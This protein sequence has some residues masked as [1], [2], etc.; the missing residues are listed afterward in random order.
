MSFGGYLAARAAAFE[1][2]LRAAVFFD[3][4]YDFHETLRKL[5]PGGDGGLR[6][7]GSAICEWIVQE[8]M[9]ANTALRWTVI[10]GIWTFGVPGSP[11]LSM[12]PRLIRLPKSPTRSAARAWS[13]RPQM[14]SSSKDSRSRCSTS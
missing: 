7:R 9:A 8:K 1:H 13:W 12:G 14:T 4:V 6:L 2:C 3:G 5:L 11:S 10:Q